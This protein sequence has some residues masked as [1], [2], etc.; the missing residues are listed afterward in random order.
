[1]ADP[2]IELF[3][4]PVEQSQLIQ[5]PGTSPYRL[6]FNKQFSL[7]TCDHCG[8][9]LKPSSDSGTK[10]FVY[11][12]KHFKQAHSE[13]VTTLERKQFILSVQS[14][15]EANSSVQGLANLEDFKL[16]IKGRQK[17]EYGPIEGLKIIRNAFQCKDCPECWSTPESMRN[18][19]CQAHQPEPHQPK[20]RHLIRD[21]STRRSVQV[22]VKGTLIPVNLGAATAPAPVHNPQVEVDLLAYYHQDADMGTRN[23]EACCI[24]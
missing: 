23:C 20:V 8:Q 14:F 16:Q 12:W 2:A 21:V 7:L 10:E 18:H 13:I 3:C 19:R 9:P 24:G 17:S 22:W 4:Q 15:F 11:I 6:R 5:V 1:M